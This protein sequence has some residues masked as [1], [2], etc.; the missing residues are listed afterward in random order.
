MFDGLKDVSSLNC[1]ARI[2]LFV[3]LNLLQTLIKPSLFLRLK[4]LITH[5]FVP[6]QF[7]SIRASRSGVFS[8]QEES[9]LTLTSCSFFM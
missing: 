1:I 4:I 8:Q 7:W 6:Q 2:P 9:D 3:L 5:F